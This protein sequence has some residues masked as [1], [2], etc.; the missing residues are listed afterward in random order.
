MEFQ[1]GIARRLHLC[2]N[3]AHKFDKEGYFCIGNGSAAKQ[4]LRNWIR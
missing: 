2:L 3:D 4:Y 1:K